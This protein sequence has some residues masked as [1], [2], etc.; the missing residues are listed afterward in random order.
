[1]L[2]GL[3]FNGSLE[4]GVKLPLGTEG[5]GWCRFRLKEGESA[6]TRPSG[7]CVTLGE[8]GGVGSGLSRIMLCL[9]ECLGDA[10][11]G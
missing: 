2:T 11:R 3:L 5:S 7:A 6:L 9:A 8:S 1:M 4:G 10:V